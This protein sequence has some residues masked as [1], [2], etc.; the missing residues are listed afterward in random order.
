MSNG[1]PY[2]YWVSVAS[3]ADGSR[4]AGVGNSLVFLSVSSPAPWLNPTLTG[5]SLTLSWILPSTSLVL[6]QSPDLA[7]ANWTNVPA[8]A[9]LATNTL[10]Y[11]VTIPLTNTQGFFRLQ[12][13]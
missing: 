3:S 1:V 7:S 5:G 10:Q 2:V 4:L 13:H 8:A 6:Q 9:T 12:T 11:Q